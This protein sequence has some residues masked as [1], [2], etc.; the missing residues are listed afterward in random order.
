[1][2]K[3]KKQKNIKL[4]ILI[5]AL[6]IVANTQTKAATKIILKLDDLSVTNN[7]CDALPVLNYLMQKQIKASFGVIAERCDATIL[8]VLSPYIEATDTKGDSIFE[9]WHHGLDHV[10]PEFDGT[11]YDYQKSHFDEANDIILQLL[12]I[13]MH[14]FGSPYNA[15]DATTN[16]VISENSNYKV[17]MF[18]DVTP[19][20][21]TGIINLTKRVNIENGTGNVDYDY[22]TENYYAKKDNYTDYMILQ[23]HPNSWTDNKINEFA[24]IIDFLIAEG[25]EF[26]N[27]YEYYLYLNETKVAVT[28]VSFEKDELTLRSG[29]TSVLNASISPVNASEKLM[30]WSTSD[31]TIATVTSHGEIYT[32][33]EGTAVITA[34]TYDGTYTANCTITVISN[35]YTPPSSPITIDSIGLSKTSLTLEEGETSALEELSSPR[36]ILLKL[37]DS[38]AR[39]GVCEATLTMDYLA[40][41]KIKSGFGVVA[42]RQDTTAYGIWEPYLNARNDN[43]DMLFEIWHHGWGHYKD[44]PLGTWE[45]SGTTYK[46]QKQYFEDANNEILDLFHVQMHGFGAP[47]NQTDNTTNQVLAENTNYKTFIFP[48]IAPHDSTGIKVM[49]NR[50]NF[51]N[52]TGIP[53]YDYFVTNYNAAKANY[54]DFMV[55]QGHPN[56]WDEAKVEEFSKVIDFLIA[57]GCEFIKPSE[58]N[59]LL[60]SSLKATIYPTNSSNEKLTWSSSN[61][62]VA[63]VS[64]KGIIT[65]ITTGT[66]T[67]T[68]SARDGSYY[69]S[70]E[71]VVTSKIPSGITINWITPQTNDQFSEGESINVEIEASD[72]E[73][74]SSV[75][76]YIDD[77]LIREDLN[78]PYEW[79]SAQRDF[80]LMNRSLGEYKL[81]AE[82]TDNLGNV[83]FSSIS[84]TVVGEILVT[85]ITILENSINL[86]VGEQDSITATITPSNASDT[87][88]TWESSNNE[89]VTINE[90]VVN[91]ISKGI[92]YITATTNDGGFYTNCFVT[93]TE[94]LSAENNLNENTGINVYP[95]PA[96]KDVAIKFSL[97]NSENIFIYISD[98]Q[99]KNIANIANENLQAGTHLYKWNM[100]N[101][102]SNKI[103][104][105]LYLVNILS[106]NAIKTTQLIVL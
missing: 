21:S 92:A 1:M 65:A 5:F 36:K 88:I 27:P 51:E 54:T 47:F 33:N 28:G 46:V 71:V 2:K 67:I 6:S 100:K 76:L 102:R 40:E 24:Q 95:N 55:L 41:N 91:A 14:S 90:G 68:C 101:D 77:V 78:A 13:Q 34:K 99:G 60:E 96:T 82:A 62:A 16:T 58:Y 39:S 38:E 25:C 17:L 94:A 80:S 83:E 15:T 29:E 3:N 56:V 18:A 9:I 106:E 81:K 89:I 57:E 84:V 35:G 7:E 52:G 11:G 69:A 10:N 37:D 79:G 12:G 74:I 93:V 20:T 63:T 98:L 50:V 105:G 30:S 49:Q 8:P 70:C 23:G 53:D 22:F 86:S 104:P 61:N 48:K 85:D 75:K 97:E 31:N 103:K 87:T 32:L 26:V 45:F 42:N 4:F 66:T 44:M 43:G 59:Q 73:S 72:D 64:Q 19:S